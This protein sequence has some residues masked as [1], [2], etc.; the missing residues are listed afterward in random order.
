MIDNIK[1][2]IKVGEVI[3]Q[4]MLKLNEY[5]REYELDHNNIFEV[6]ETNIEYQSFLIKYPK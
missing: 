4:V 2:F 1:M 3:Y 5:T 6:A